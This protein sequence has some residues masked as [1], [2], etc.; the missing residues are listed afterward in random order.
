ML[1]LDRKRFAWLAREVR[2][3]TPNPTARDEA[4]W[5]DGQGETR[6]DRAIRMRGFVEALYK[7]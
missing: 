4:I 5:G 1:F 2:A 6:L 3:S 7:L